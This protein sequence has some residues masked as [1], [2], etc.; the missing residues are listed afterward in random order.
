[1]IPVGTLS[2]VLILVVYQLDKVIKVHSGKFVDYLFEAPRLSR[3]KVTGMC[4]QGY[5]VHQ[6]V[7]YIY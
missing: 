6:G 5:G 7:G 1:M 2:T 3:Q 4:R